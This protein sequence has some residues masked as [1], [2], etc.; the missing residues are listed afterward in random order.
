MCS[1]VLLKEKKSEESKDK[2]KSY[3]EM[4]TYSC[5]KV[6]WN[7]P[8]VTYTYHKVTFTNL[9]KTQSE[10]KMTYSYSEMTRSCQKVA[11]LVS[12]INPI[13]KKSWQF[14]SFRF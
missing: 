6:T 9:Q 13:M 4:V 1:L 11:Y 8:K 12:I 14:Y 10:P 5:L 3:G 2:I 7:D